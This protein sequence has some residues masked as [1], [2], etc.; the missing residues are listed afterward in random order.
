LGFIVE[1]T[2][3]L[4]E[5]PTRRPRSGEAPLLKTRALYHRAT[6][7]MNGD[8]IA[9]PFAG[10]ATSQQWCGNLVY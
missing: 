5:M 10:H 8:C 1:A 9:P 3:R 2:R 6:I 4:M 7:A